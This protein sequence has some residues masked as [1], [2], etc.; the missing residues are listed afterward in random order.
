MQYA[1]EQAKGITGTSTACVLTLSDDL[2]LQASNLGDS[3]FIVV[4]ESKV[5]LCSEDQ[6][7][8]WNM[9]YQIG[10]TSN[11]SPKT[12]ANNYTLTLKANDYIVVGTDGLFDNLQHSEIISQLKGDNC[13]SIAA[14]ILEKTINT[15]LNT[16]ANTPFAKDAK[17]A[18]KPWYG[19]KQDDI[20]VIVV[21]IL[22]TRMRNSS[23]PP[24]WCH[25][26]NSPIFKYQIQYPTASVGRVRGGIW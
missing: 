24:C 26:S 3:R 25:G 14:T 20:T 5:I 13:Q 15:S 21:K 12:H 7:I 23:I 22:S 10:S 18:G 4:R 19:G 6:Q 11:M 2:Q 1:Y 17:K 9:P 8:E 16:R